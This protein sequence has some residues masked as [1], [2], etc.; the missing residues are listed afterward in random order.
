MVG[1]L[2]AAGQF[3]S[4]RMLASLAAVLAVGLGMVLPR[5]P[6]AWASGSRWWS[7][8]RRCWP[9]PG[10]RGS[11]CRRRSAW[12]GA[13]LAVGTSW[14]V[15]LAVT[16]AWAAAVWVLSAVLLVCRDV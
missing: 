11:G 14:S 12:G 4:G 7:R 9:G 15:G 1:V 13:F 2:A 10:A 8:C 3:A 16:V 5:R 6:A